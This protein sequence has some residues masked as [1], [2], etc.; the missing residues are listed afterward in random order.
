MS[1]I[2]TANQ[3]STSADDNPDEDNYTEN[4]TYRTL[5]TLN[6]H[7]LFYVNTWYKYTPGIVTWV[8]LGQCNL[9]NIGSFTEIVF[10]SS[11]Y[12]N[13]GPS[14]SWNGKVYAMTFTY[15]EAA[16]K[17]LSAKLLTCNAK[18]QRKLAVVNGIESY[19]SKVDSLSNQTRLIGVSNESTANK[20]RRASLATKAL[21][22][23]LKTEN[24]YLNSGA[25]QASFASA[26][27]RKAANKIRKIDS[28]LSSQVSCVNSNNISI[29]DDAISVYL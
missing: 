8:T 18:A 9:I 15:Q 10:P 1:N 2:N 12:F 25:Y 6:G 24:V 20:V 7:T 5:L 21:A 14:L 27:N 23:N 11:I 3:Y 16:I 22:L 28:S 13:M 26:S 19:L 4:S 17:K 29:K